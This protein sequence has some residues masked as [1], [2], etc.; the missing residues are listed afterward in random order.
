MEKGQVRKTEKDWGTWKCLVDSNGREVCL[1]E[2]IG[3]EPR[4]LEAGMQISS[5]DLKFHKTSDNWSF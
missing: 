3:S 2:V 1:L 4:I 5:K